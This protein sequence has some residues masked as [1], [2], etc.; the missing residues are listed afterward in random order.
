MRCKSCDC[1]LYSHDLKD[2]PDGTLE[3]LCSVCRFLSNE[4]DSVLYRHYEHSDLTEQ[5]FEIY[6]DDVS[7]DD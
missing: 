2:K 4:Q 3:D 1:E 7:E 6:F 5:P